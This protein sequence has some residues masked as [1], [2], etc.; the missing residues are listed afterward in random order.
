M[1][2]QYYWKWTKTRNSEPDARYRVLYASVWK[3]FFF[4]Y[5]LLQ[6]DLELW[7]FN[8]KILCSSLSQNVSLLKVLDENVDV[9]FQI[10]RWLNAFCSMF[11][12]TVIYWKVLDW[13]SPNLQHCCVLVQRRR[14][15]IWGQRIH[16]LSFDPQIRSLHLCTKMHQCSKFGRRLQIWGQR[17]HFLSF[18]PQIRSLHLSTKGFRFGVKWSPFYPSTP[19]SEAFISVPKC[20]SAVSWWKSV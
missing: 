4:Q 8:P 9:V 11:Y 14:L 2:C 20:F 3:A 18:D 17:I 6:R 16:F 15:Q 19:K 13:F 12:S 5:I 1:G 7:P 10:S